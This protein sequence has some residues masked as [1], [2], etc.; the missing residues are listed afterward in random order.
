[1]TDIYQRRPTTNSGIGIGGGNFVLFGIAGGLIIAHFIG[2][3]ISGYL[4]PNRTFYLGAPYGRIIKL[5]CILLLAAALIDFFIP[6]S[7]FYYNLVALTTGMQNAMTSRFFLF[8][9]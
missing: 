7:L 1:M 3:T 4:V 9:T 2:A 6:D 8:Y 5:G